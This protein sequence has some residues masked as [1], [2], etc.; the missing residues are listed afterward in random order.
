MCI[1]AQC[2]NCAR[3]GTWVVGRLAGG[4]SKHLHEQHKTAQLSTDPSLL[5]RIAAA[6]PP[7][8][9][10]GR[11]GGEALPLEV[12]MQQMAAALRGLALSN[13]AAPKWDVNV[14]NQVSVRA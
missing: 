13:P 2:C 7:G 6:G 8:R 9:G 3:A 10:G 5:C 14:Y 11:A 4:A 1:T 12:G